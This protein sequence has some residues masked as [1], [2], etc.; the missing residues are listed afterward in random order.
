[1]TPLYWF[2]RASFWANNATDSRI[3]LRIAPELLVL[4]EDVIGS[5]LDFS[6]IRLRNATLVQ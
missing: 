3:E 6:G 1:M 4:W 2:P 5:T